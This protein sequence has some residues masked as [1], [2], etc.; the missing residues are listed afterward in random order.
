M[1]RPAVVLAAAVSQFLLAGCDS[2]ALDQQ[3]EELCE[4]AEG[5]KVDETVTVQPVMFDHN[6]D[7]FP[8]RRLRPESLRLGA[9]DRL[10]QQAV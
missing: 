2:Y 6:G 3:T 10:L 9:H 8:G 5:I 7:P 4:K 1:R